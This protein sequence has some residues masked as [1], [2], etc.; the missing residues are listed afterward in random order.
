MSARYGVP[1]EC[2]RFFGRDAVIAA[3][4][5]HWECGRLVTLSGPGG[6][7]KSRLA[8]RVAHEVARSYRHGALRVELTHL[9]DDAE[10][11]AGEL[12]TA[13][14]IMDNS[15]VSRARVVEHL[16]DKHM[17]LVL[18]N[19]EHVVGALRPLLVELLAAAPSLHILTTSRVSLRLDEE[20]LQTV[21]PLR[22]SVPDPH[23]RSEAAQLFLDRA[24]A[25]NAAVDP[26]RHR[27]VEDICRALHGIPLAIR[28][29]AGWLRS[30]SL[31]EVAHDL[32]TDPI[33]P[34]TEA[35]DTTRQSLSPDEVRLWAIA[36]AFRGG[37]R[38]KALQDIYL[39]LGLDPEPVPDLLSGL[40][41]KS[42]VERADR[43]HHTRFDFLETVRLYGQRL[44]IPDLP[45][46]AIVAA[47]ADYFVDFGRRAADEW[48]GELEIT[49]M[50]VL[51]AEDANLRA[52]LAHLIGAHRHDDA[53]QLCLRIARSRADIFAGSLNAS[54][55]RF[56]W[57]L[58]EIGDRASRGRLLAVA[59]SAWVATVQGHTEQADTL[60]RETDRLL[61]RLRLH[62][63]P[64]LIVRF[65]RA[66]AVMLT[67]QNLDRARTSVPM[68]ADIVANADD[69]PDLTDGARHMAMLF[70]AIA[71]GFY[72]DPD[73]ALAVSRGVL[74]DA[75][76]HQAPWAISW[77]LWTVALAEFQRG[78]LAAALRHA[79]HALGIQREY[80]EKWGRA[81]S[82]WLIA[83]I[84]GERGEHAPAALLMG[85]ARR[86]LRYADLAI[87]G[88]LP[89]L[90]LTLRA[91][92]RG[93]RALAGYDAEVQ[94]GTTRG[95]DEICA[96]ALSTGAT[97]DKALG[98]RPY[99]FTAREYEVALEAAKGHQN[100]DIAA[101]LGISPRTVE[102]HVYRLLIKA[103]VA[104]E[105]LA[106]ALVRHSS[107]TARDITGQA[108][109][110]YGRS[111][112]GSS[113]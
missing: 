87:A 96:L 11:L 10:Q 5:E 71:A 97:E 27:A 69:D 17:L 14:G 41:D 102:T 107:A 111:S 100:Q 93:R 16:R 88:L 48:F 9:D 35:L 84:R 34:L 33:A 79:Q 31:T 20:R 21:P 43:Q 91:D 98:E 29:A 18:D 32:T 58:G 73:H 53:L 3:V 26:A 52:A 7:G 1:A 106:V 36:S 50:R 19:C 92:A 95:Y 78:D 108:R 83:V 68:L 59:M 6:I 47:H 40:M 28:V 89:F 51:A 2:G 55:R 90:E 104:R 94:R 101:T 45:P 12:A 38:L 49:W 15:T 42:L 110:R 46:H 44:R 56:T 81:W 8:L 82:L 72:A 86:Q 70:H 99:G 67:E 4:R 85:G 24:A 54:R 61:R 105:E 66:T 37:F 64:P 109:R 13:L 77:A 112:T 25:I 30:R 65:A 113:W 22:T 39:A 76:R 80:D 74:D 57:V 75:E 63:H 103:G 62:E 60:T 23:T